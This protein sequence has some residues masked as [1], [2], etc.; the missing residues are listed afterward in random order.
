MITG[1]SPLFGMGAPE[2]LARAL[3]CSHEKLIRLAETAGDHYKSTARKKAGAPGKFRKID[4]P[5]F[6]LKTLQKDIKNRLFGAIQFPPTMRGGIKG[7]GALS[8]AQMHVGKPE[9][10]KIDLKN[11]FPKTSNLA[12]YRQLIR[13]FGCA[14]EIASLVTKLTTFQRMVPQG[15]PTSSVIV[16]LA[17]LPLHDQLLDYCKGKGW[18]FS[19]WV[20]DLVVSGKGLRAGIGDMIGIIHSHRYTARVNKIKVMKNGKDP[21]DVLGYNVNQKATVSRK[22]IEGIGKEILSHKGK[23]AIPRYQRTSILGKINYVA[24]SKSQAHRVEKLKKLAEAV[25]PKSSLEIK[26]PNL[27]QRVTI[28]SPHKIWPRL[29][30][31]R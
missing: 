3:K 31:P 15:A 17:L 6:E 19:M 22:R 27:E 4:N 13:V 20:D 23:S 16:N 12:V 1:E 8:T 24:S 5:D 7:R 29:R 21:Q 26:R 11:C 9:V 30:K 18:G 25:L 28:K 14:P 2:S 10:L